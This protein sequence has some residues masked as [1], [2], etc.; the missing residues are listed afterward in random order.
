[1]GRFGVR[2]FVVTSAVFLGLA[3]TPDPLFAQHGGGHSGGGGG[4]H[5]GGGGS[6]HG[7]GGESH[8]GMRSYG[9]GREGGG[10][11]GSSAAPYGGRTMGGSRGNSSS[12]AGRN[13]GPHAGRGFGSGVNHASNIHP[14]INDGQ[15]HSFGST[16]ASARFGSGFVGGT[17]R[18]IPGFGWGG[19]GWGGGR[20]R[21]CCWGGWGFGFGG[22]YWGAYWGPAWGFGWNPWWYSP[23]WGYDAYWLGTPY[24]YYPDYSY[25]WSDNPPYRSDPSP[26][27]G[28]KGKGKTAPVLN[29]PGSTFKDNTSA[30]GEPPAD[31]NTNQ[32]G[33]TPVPAPNPVLATHSLI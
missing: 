29:Q 21:G 28:S 16:N 6:F 18:T 4:S 26:D 33:N 24:A 1:M 12:M 19:R 3:L 11:R 2:S 14:A 10:S 30:S 32:H 7:G 22:P 13:G 9:G 23:Y 27:N 31:G 5:S 8:G 25:D 17:S 20:G 15:W